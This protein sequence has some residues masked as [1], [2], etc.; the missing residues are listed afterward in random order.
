MGKQLCS[1]DLRSMYTASRS[2]KI[3]LSA[4]YRLTLF[5]LL[6]YGPVTEC[7]FIQ[8]CKIMYLICS[9][10]GTFRN[11]A[12]QCTLGILEHV[13]GLNLISFVET[14]CTLQTVQLDCSMMCSLLYLALQLKVQACA[15]QHSNV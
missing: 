13:H 5:C 7:M 2:S 1:R 8:S 12:E 9:D 15:L 6:Q 4:L 3:H 10:P 11:P 14:D